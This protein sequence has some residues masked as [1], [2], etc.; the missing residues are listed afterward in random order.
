MA[1]R[2]LRAGML[3]LA[4]ALGAP[5]V[6]LA[7]ACATPTMAQTAQG[8]AEDIEIVYGEWRDEA[9]ER[10][11]PY[12]LY[13]PA[14]RAAAPIVIF[15]HGLGGNREAAGYL[16]E[17]LAANGF[18]AL[19]IQHPG[20]DESLLQGGGGMERL[21][22]SVRDARS[23]A[24]RF[25]DVRFAIDQLERENA[26]GRFAG[27]FDLTRI[28]MSG[29]SYGALTT[30]IAVGQRPAAGPAERFRDARIDAAIAYSPN[31]PRNQ[32]PGPALADIRTPILH[33]T[34][35]N[36]R[37]PLDLEMTPEGRQIP[38]RTITGADQFLIVF[39]GGEHTIFSGRL[40]RSGRMSADHEA[41]TEAIQR[42][43]LNFWRAY[44]LAD[45]DAL[46][47]MC[48]LPARVDAIGTGEVRAER[49]EG[50]AP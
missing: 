28:G 1:F 3:G 2:P 8:A 27:R 26:N 42:E 31:A 37:T 43:T 36:D 34:G 5:I 9:R 4:L 7:G 39:D 14:A 17:H 24:A 19:S 20:S 32:D 44:L 46:A 18:A 23:A 47:A 22:E 33:F 41:Q 45:A 11:V 13:L 38:F 35:T 15:S 25:G 29:H 30:L 40:Q 21:R 49:C 12:K 48:G 16:L 50:A 10:S 6:L